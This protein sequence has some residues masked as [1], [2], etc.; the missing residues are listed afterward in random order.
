MLCRATPVGRGVYRKYKIMEIMQF[1]FSSL[2]SPNHT[3]GFLL[4]AYMS[5]MKIIGFVFRKLKIL[6]L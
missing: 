5:Y 3:G 4:F 1:R 2:S 6:G